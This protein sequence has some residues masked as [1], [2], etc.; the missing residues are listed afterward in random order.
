MYLIGTRE[1]SKPS[2]VSGFSIDNFRKFREI[3]AGMLKKN[4]RERLSFRELL[5][6]VHTFSNITSFHETKVFSMESLVGDEVKKFS[7]QVLV[8]GADI[9]RTR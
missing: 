3:L 1:A 6:Q 2:Q 8:V 7:S 5:G 4:P 9:T